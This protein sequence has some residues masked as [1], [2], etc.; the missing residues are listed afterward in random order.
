MSRF[1][2][3]IRFE[4]GYYH[5][6]RY[7]QARVNRTF[8]AFYPG[9]KPL[10]LSA[11]LTPSED[12]GRQKLRVVYDGKSHHVERTPYEPKN[13][14]SF[15]VVYA[16]I[17]YS[18]KY[19]DRAQLND[20]LKNST[21]DEIIIMKDGLITDSSYSNLA[22]F[23]GSNWW[24]PK[25]PLLSGVRRAQLLEQ[26]TL[27]EMDIKVEHLSSFEKV[28]L[29]NAMLDLGDICLPTNQIVTEN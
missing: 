8:S 21:A 9:T 16:D 23:D 14:Q 25:Q 13:I 7:H 12:S 2:E 22:F 15:E 29:I 26:G 28:S 3:T 10:D 11:V 19:A 27:Q 18:F 6:L 20:L 24:T 5:L 4:G 1:I 17:D